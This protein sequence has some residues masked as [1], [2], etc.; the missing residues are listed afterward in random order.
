MDNESSKIYVDWKGTG[1]RI[2]ELMRDKKYTLDVFADILDINPERFKH[3]LYG[4]RKIPY[5]IC[6]SIKE[7]FKL[8]SV[9][10]IYVIGRRAESG[11]VEDE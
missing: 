8:K 7:E 5:E 1:K 9:E 2:R 10:D 4:E 6:A 3:Y 11:G